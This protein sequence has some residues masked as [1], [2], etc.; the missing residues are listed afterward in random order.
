MDG[1]SDAKKSSPTAGP[2]EALTPPERGTLRVGEPADVA[3]GLPAVTSSLGYTVQ[4]AG[5]VRGTR[6]LLKVNQDGGFDCPSC[7]WPDPKDRAVV[8]FCENGARA[9]ADEATTR[10]VDPDFFTRYSVAELAERSDLWINAQ[11]RLTHPMVLR[12]GATHYEPISWDA[13]FETIGTTLKGLSDPRRAVFYTSG[14]TSNE[15]AFLYQ[16]FVRSFG[17]NNLPDCSNMCHE[18][19]GAGLSKAIGIGKG[20]VTLEDFAKSKL[21]YV[22]GQNPGTNHPRM[23]SALREA[24]LAGARI[25]AVNPLREAGLVRFKHPQK[26]GD[27]L[28]AGVALADV[29]LR[30]NVGGD[31]ALL[32]G[33]MKALYALER[34][35]PGSAFDQAFLDERTE[36]V[37]AVL[38]DLDA[39]QWETIVEESGVARKEIEALAKEHANANSVIACWAMGITQH[40]HGVGNV[41][42]IANL[43]L[44]GGHVGKPGAGLCPVR[45]HSNVQG[46]RTVGIWEKF[47]PWGPAMEETFG[48]ELPRETG[49]DV[50]EAIHAMAEGNVDVFFA[51]GGNFVSAT[52]DTLATAA[53]LQQC[54]LTVHVSTK[55]NRSHLIPGKDALILPCLARSEH[56]FHQGAARFVTVENSMGIVHRSVGNLK[57]ASPELISEPEIVGRLAEAALGSSHAVPWRTLAADYDGIRDKIAA[58]VPGFDDYNARVRKPGGFA[59]PNGPREGRFT[60]ASGKAHFFVHAIPDMSLEDGR[61]WLT[62]IRT[63]DQFNTVVYGEDDR[64]RGIYGHRRVVL[65]HAEDLA[66]RKIRVGDAVRVVS[67]HEGKTREADDFIALAYDI[68][69]G[70]VAAYFPEANVLVPLEHV[71]EV[72]NTPASKAIAVTVTPS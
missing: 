35:N 41:Q 10:R 27:V 4:Q 19:S 20:T 3:A 40:R 67:H 14:R 45:G 69:R 32:K 64:Y 65:M 7:A 63:H 48:V 5:I 58:V 12:A 56:D 52:P 54:A 9:V 21:I 31:I 34:D 71:A 66:E 55:L 6:A 8:E 23:L 26:V 50:V 30:V 11:G 72:S 46:D 53:A 16:L 42:T 61:L 13:A 25:V 1:S 39:T 44:L 51:M 18:S 47:P 36:G 59:L 29:Y 22:I 24:K 38:D 49:F 17:C 60:T 43:L 37:Q 70:S 2:I 15:A 33:L 62:T 28:G 57:P 68:P